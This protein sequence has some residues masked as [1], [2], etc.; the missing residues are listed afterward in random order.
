MGRGGGEDL[1]P[2][3]VR[4]AALGGYGMQV[5]AAVLDARPKIV[6]EV[7]S[8]RASAVG[9]PFSSFLSP[10]VLGLRII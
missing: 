6:L 2:Q 4:A 1:T 8:E 3:E 10:I 9:W 5:V 7:V